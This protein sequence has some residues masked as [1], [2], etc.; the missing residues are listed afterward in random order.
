MHTD[1]CGL[2]PESLGDNKYFISFID[3]CTR[4]VW[5]YFL[6]EKSAA[7]S[8]F[9]IFKAMTERES[10]NRIKILRSDTG[11]EYTSNEFKRYSSIEGI[12]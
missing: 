6:K 3:D 4:K 7:F 5:I 2:F 8:M 10:G 12:Q 11:G 9:K 1:L